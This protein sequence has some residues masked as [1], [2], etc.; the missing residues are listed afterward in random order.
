MANNDEILN[1]DTEKDTHGLA[2][3]TGVV[4]KEGLPTIEEK[5]VKLTANFLDM[6]ENL[7]G[8]AYT[9][10]KKAMSKA[11]AKKMLE[12]YAVDSDALTFE[13]ISNIYKATINSLTGEL[14]SY[15]MVIVLAKVAP[16]SYELA[17][18]P[19]PASEYW[20]TGDTE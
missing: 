6:A 18:E 9:A 1:T 10:D 8:K 15:P 5:V 2:K 13:T 17:R 16:S 7:T 12:R 11:W 4:K 3:S 14:P 20:G 19:I